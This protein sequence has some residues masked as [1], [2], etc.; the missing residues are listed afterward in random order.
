MTVTLVNMTLGEE[1]L[2]NTLSNLLRDR[3]WE[4]FFQISCDPWHETKMSQS[5]MRGGHLAAEDGFLEE[6]IE[7]EVLQVRV[8]VKG[9]LDV[10]KKHTVK[11]KQRKKSLLRFFTRHHHFEEHEN[12]PRKYKARTCSTSRCD[13][14]KS[15]FT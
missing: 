13:G 3:K 2:L 4:L 12:I 9:L 5:G 15:Q 10:T 11:V 7:Q 14:K 6:V 1:Y 8:L